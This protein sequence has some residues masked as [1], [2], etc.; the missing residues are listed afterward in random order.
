MPNELDTSLQPLYDPRNKLNDL[1]SKEWTYALGSV[2]FT[3]YPTR[4]ANSMAHH[5]RR[6][7]PSPKPPQLIAEL[8]QFFTKKHGH[9]LDLF[10]GAGGSLLACSLEQ[11]NGVGIELNPEYQQLYEQ[12]STYLELPTQRYVIG[13][14]CQADTYDQISTHP[15]DL[16]IADPPY[17]SM[18]ARKRTGHRAKRGTSDATPF[19]NHSADLGNMEREEF[20]ARLV[21]AMRH[22]L[23]HLR[24]H[25]HVI[26]FIK[27]LQPTADHH[28]MLHAD[29][30][31]A[32]KVVEGLRFRGYRI[33]HDANINRF[34][35][36]YPHTFVSNQ[37]HQFILI[38]RKE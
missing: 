5:I 28:N 26:M 23:P 22:A 8:L 18:L 12:A 20:F 17:G 36:G 10:S 9:V 4:G 2:L 33:W 38:F 35:F 32:L 11:R 30:V 1:S 3:R 21:T 14:V 37:T 27:D 13:D 7:H 29:V 15:F 6:A 31:E 25:G 34:P 16:I 24:H 19:S